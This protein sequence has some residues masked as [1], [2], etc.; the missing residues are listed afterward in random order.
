MALSIDLP[1]TAGRLSRY[2]LTGTPVAVPQGPHAFTRIAFSAAHVVADPFTATEPGIG[3]AIDWAPTLAFRR[4]LLD[5]GLGIAEA[6]DTAQR[7]MG[8]DWPGARELIRQSL[9]AATPAERDRIFCGV[10]TDQL[11]P[12]AARD[13]DHVTAAYLDQLHAVQGMGGRVILMASRALARVARSPEDYA[14]VYRRVLAEAEHPV[15]LHW[16]GDMFDPALKGYWGA[17]GYE[18]ALE[19]AL[20]VIAENAAKVDGIKISLLDAEKEVRMRRRLPAGVKIYTGDD[21]N[22]PDL[23]RGDAQGFSH[24][25]LGIFDPIAPSASAALAALAKGDVAAY[26]RIFAPTVPLSRHI[27]R[28]PTQYYKTGVVFMAYLNGWQDHFVMVGGAHAMRPLPYFTD[29]FRLADAA[30]L[31]RDPDLAVVRMQRLLALYGVGA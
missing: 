7:G 26:D 22:Y 9:A 30:G 21:F 15:I 28:A 5:L 18:A 2:R 3:P 31:L 25:L 19:T 14:T 20:G 27:F 24:A 13:I 4:H 12:A 11:D 8:L 29:L 23:I 17:D 6:M 16:L 1:D 10:G